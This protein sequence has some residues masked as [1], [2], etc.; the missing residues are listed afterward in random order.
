M[1]R[2]YSILQVKSIEEDEEQEMSIEGI[3]STPTPDRMGDIVEPKGAK[4][5]LP[6]PL[7]WQHMHSQPVGLV[8]FAK[9]NKDGIPFKATLPYIK[10]AGVLK[11]RV[12][13]ARQSLK[14]G[15]VLAVS[16]GFRAVRDAIEALPGGG[17]RFKEWEWLELS[18]VTVPAN[19]DATI[20]SIKAIDQQLL[21]AAG[22]RKPG[23]VKLLSPSPGDSGKPAV[24]NGAIS[25]IPR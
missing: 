14:A 22:E 16:I 17:L 11:D 13:L 21:A 19:A 5:R 18:L 15:L 6:M 20:T 7:L 12:D 24:R 2:A 1:D 25:L 23:V 4:F 8:R 3:A 10:E 9:P